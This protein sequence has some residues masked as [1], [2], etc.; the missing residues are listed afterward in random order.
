MPHLRHYGIPSHK[1]PPTRSAR[2]SI[3]HPMPSLYPASYPTIPSS[4][5][6]KILLSC[7]HLSLLRQAR[8][9]RRTQQFCANTTSLAR[10]LRH[11]RCIPHG[12]AGTGSVFPVTLVTFIESSTS[13]ATYSTLTSS[14]LLRNATTKKNS[15]GRGERQKSEGSGEGKNLVEAGSLHIG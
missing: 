5:H 3:S 1:T 11:M 9:R 4:P 2:A 10:P 6:P 8:H 12:L 13:G 15:R 14:E 7:L